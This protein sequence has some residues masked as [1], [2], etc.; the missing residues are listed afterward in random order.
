MPS[1][2]SVSVTPTVA[3]P[4]PSITLVVPGEVI[5]T[6]ALSLSTTSIVCEVLAEALAV[7]VTLNA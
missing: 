3:A 5:A 1:V 6:L 7:L 2:V 4:L